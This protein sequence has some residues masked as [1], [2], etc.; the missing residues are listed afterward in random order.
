[1][2]KRSQMKI[3]SVAECAPWSIRQYF[4]LYETRVGLESLFGLLFEWPLKTGSTVLK[5]H[6]RLREYD[7][8]IPQL[9]DWSVYC[10]SH[11]AT[12]CFSRRDTD[13]NLFKAKYVYF[14]FSSI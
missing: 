3:E 2:A 12:S 8:Q 9:Q 13:N 5:S 1:M 7:Q 11:T 4:D 6:I 14:I 10:N